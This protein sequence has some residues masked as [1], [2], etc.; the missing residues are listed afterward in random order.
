MRREED[1][2]QVENAPLVISLSHRAAL[3][4]SSHASWLSYHLLLA[5]LVGIDVVG[6]PDLRQGGAHAGGVASQ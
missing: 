4:S 3:L 5:S 2:A 6:T 1:N